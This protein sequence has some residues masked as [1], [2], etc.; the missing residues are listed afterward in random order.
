VENGVR[1]RDLDARFVYAATK[2]A[3]RLSDGD[4]VDGM[5]G[6]M[7]QCPKCSEGLERGEEDGRRFVRGAHYIRIFFAN[8]RGVAA[9][10]PDA[11]L[12]SDGT[13]NPQWQMRGTSIDDL[14]LTPSINCD[15]PWKD[16]NGVEH[17]SSCKFHGWVTNGDAA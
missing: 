2:G 8:P 15:I 9:A 13:A 7:F 16:A 6:V 14:T 12:R 3:S 4:A 10:P 17:E 11:D 1:L 5:Q